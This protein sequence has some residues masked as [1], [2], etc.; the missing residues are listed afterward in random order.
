MQSD[1]DTLIANLTQEFRGNCSAVKYTLYQLFD[2][3]GTMILDPEEAFNSTDDDIMDDD[4]P[5]MD[6]PHFQM[7]YAADVSWTVVFSI[8]ITCAIL[9]NLVVFWIV[10]GKWIQCYQL[11]VKNELC[12]YRPGRANWEISWLICLSDFTWNQFWSFWPFEQ[13]WILGTFDIFKCEIFTKIKIR[14]FQNW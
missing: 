11:F 14:S 8:M 3:N 10:L 7:P 4:D 5:S 2:S 6:K 1:L 9:G 12:R 13:L